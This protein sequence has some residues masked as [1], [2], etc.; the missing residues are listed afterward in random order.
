ML[1]ID[2]MADDGDLA[3]G[4]FRRFGGNHYFFVVAP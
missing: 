4:A 1:V 2:E 3:T